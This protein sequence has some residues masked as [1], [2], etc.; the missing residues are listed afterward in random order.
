MDAAQQEATARARELQRSW[1]GEPL[2][3]LFRRLID[4]LGLN[5]ARLAA[6]LGLSA[7]ML[8]QLMSGQR[9]KIGN[10]AVVQR[11]QALQD[12]AGQVADGSVSAGEA[13]DRMEEIKKTAGGSVLNNTAQQTS[14]TGATTVRRVVR[15]IQSL[16]RSVSDAGDIIDAANTLAP[17]HPELAEFLRVYGA[18]RTADAVA[19]YE[20]HQS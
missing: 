10:P 17:A 6:V 16:L 19:H 4:D 13:T 2:G 1:Y 20:A 14:S 8:S 15:E 11:V 9:A 7:P 12:L 18:G 3:A 5:Q